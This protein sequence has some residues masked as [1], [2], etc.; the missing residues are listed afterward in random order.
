M[1]YSLD[2]IIPTL[3]LDKIIDISHSSGP[4]DVVEFMQPHSPLEYPTHKIFFFFFFGN[5][6][7]PCFPFDGCVYV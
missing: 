4:K 1:E 7:N 6:G 3:S 2:M 5:Q